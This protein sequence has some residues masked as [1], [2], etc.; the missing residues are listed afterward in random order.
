MHLYILYG[1]VQCCEDAAGVEQNYLA[2]F[3]IITII[4][5]IVII[6]IIIIIIIFI[7]I[8]IITCVCLCMHTHVCVCVCVCVH[9]CVCVCACMS[10]CMHACVCAYAHVCVHACVC[11]CSTHVCMWLVSLHLC[12]TR[13]LNISCVS[14]HPPQ[15]NRSVLQEEHPQCPGVRAGRGLCHLSRLLHLRWLFPLRCL[16]GRTGRDGR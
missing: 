4:I 8:I 12:M 3:Y 6:I 2:F 11:A 13:D 1:C 7:I 5:I 16:P 10:A 15:I 9:V 14:Q